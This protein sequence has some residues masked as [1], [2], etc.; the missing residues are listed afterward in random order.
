MLPEMK[1]LPA[2]AYVYVI[3]TDDGPQKIGI[4]NDPKSRMAMLQIGN[5]ASLVLSLA[6]PG[7]RIEALDVELYAH[8]LLRNFRVR[9]EWFNVSPD[10]AM[11]AVSE[12]LEA[13]RSGKKISK[14]ERAIKPKSLPPLPDHET[15]DEK[16]ARIKREGEDLRTWREAYGWTQEEAGAAL[17]TS[18]DAVRQWERGR[19]EI[20]GPVRML[21]R[22][23]DRH[24]PIEE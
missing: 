8:W 7:T 1:T 13:V 15:P 5:H 4:A 9:G 19:R 2:P 12:A 17:G 20:P 11:K 22:Y 16:D 21:R 24:G 14:P 23:I 3:G 6:V 18:K 10:E